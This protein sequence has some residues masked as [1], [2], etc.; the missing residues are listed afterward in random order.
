MMKLILYEIKKLQ[1][2]RLLT[3]LGL[4]AV[5]VCLHFAYTSAEPPDYDEAAVRTVIARFASDTEHTYRIWEEKQAAY[6]AFLETAESDTLP[7]E[8]C[9]YDVYRRA[10]ERFSRQTRYHDRLESV[11]RQTQGTDAKSVLL[12]DVYTK[13]L[14]L[15]LSYDGTDALPELFDALWL[16]S[17]FVFL[18]SVLTGISVSHADRRQGMELL[19]FSAPNGRARMR[20]SKLVAAQT[21]AFAFCTLLFACAVLIFAFGNGFVAWNAYLQNHA[22]FFVCPYPLTVWQAVLLLYLFTSLSAFVLIALSCVI[23]KHAKHQAVL[24]AEASFVLLVLAACAFWEHPEAGSLIHLISPFSFCGGAAAFGHLYAV[25][26][27]NF[28][29]GG[30]PFVLGIWGALGILLGAYDVFFHVRT[31]A[32]KPKRVRM[33]SLPSLHIPRRAKTVCAFEAYK[34]LVSNRALWLFVPVLFLFCIQA[35]NAITPDQGYGEAVYRAYM[36]RLQGVYTDE[37]QSQID[38]SLAGA[39]QMLSQKQEMET[40]FADGN[41]TRA[42]MEDFMRRYGRARLEE[43]ALSRVASRLADVRASLTNGIPAEIVYD[44][45]WNAFFSLR[46]SPLPFLLLCAVCCGLFAEE[47]RCGMHRL[48]PHAVRKP[49]ARAKH[50]FAIVLVLLTALLFEAVP[51]ILLVCRTSLPSALSPSASIPSVQA[52]SACPVWVSACLSVFCR[53]AGYLT[54]ALVCTA[55]SRLI[56]QKHAA[57]VCGML[58]ALPWFL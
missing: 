20:M 42:E 5:C 22:S 43:D 32:S 18:F 25:Q 33:L 13:N 14:S 44:S 40:A 11:L 26:I 51:I 36:E 30:L 17:L 8:L 9:D 24:L 38:R 47:Y 39:Q 55:A 56:R 37:K 4:L 45:G 54:A 57:F 52:L 6:R 41:V 34:Q 23:G 31:A 28:A 1:S 2:D 58:C 48:F 53:I 27:G 16:C 10:W 21:C 49:I 29:C 35:S 7:T 46:A 19:L 50:R 3:V 15:K 12:R